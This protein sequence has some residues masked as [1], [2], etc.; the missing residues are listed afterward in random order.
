MKKL[1]IKSVYPVMSKSLCEK[2]KSKCTLIGSL[3]C[4]N[5]CNEELFG[6]KY[7]DYC[8]KSKVGQPCKYFKRRETE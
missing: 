3:F 6:C 7:K 5:S 1:K 8:C 2:C 4:K